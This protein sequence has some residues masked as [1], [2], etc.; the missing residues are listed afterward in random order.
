M[1]DERNLLRLMGVREEQGER[2]EN[3][4]GHER[5]IGASVWSASNLLVD[6]WSTVRIRADSHWYEVWNKAQIS[7]TPIFSIII[8]C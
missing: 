5:G 7:D 8:W 4:A 3:F 6:L 1:E 2:I